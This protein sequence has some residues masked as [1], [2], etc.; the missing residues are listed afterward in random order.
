MFCLLRTGR[1]GS[2]WPHRNSA[3]TEKRRHTGDH[4]FENNP[5]LALLPHRSG[6]YQQHNLLR[7][8][9]FPAMRGL[10]EKNG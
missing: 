8:R 9:D 2:L 5:A 10:F 4:Q 7:K 3:T 6:L 1:N